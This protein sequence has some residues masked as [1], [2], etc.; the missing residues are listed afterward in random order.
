MEGWDGTTEGGV[1][2]T[3]LRRWQRFGESGAKL[4]WGGEAMA[5]RPEGRANPNQLIIDERHQAGLAQLRETLLRAF[6]SFDRLRPDSQVRPWLM[7][8]LHNT[9]V[10]DWRRKKR[11]RNVLLL[12][13]GYAPLYRARSLDDPELA[14]DGVRLVHVPRDLAAPAHRYR[15]FRWPA[16]HHRQSR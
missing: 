1:T 16:F 15:R 9:F 5:I 8:I 7:R 4:I 13:A 6:R 3:V 12:A 14:P 2:E 10:S 11:E